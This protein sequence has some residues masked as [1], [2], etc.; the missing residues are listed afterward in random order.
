MTSLGHHLIFAITLFERLKDRTVLN[1]SLLIWT[2]AAIVL[3]SAFVISRLLPVLFRRAIKRFYRHTDNDLKEFDQPLRISFSFLM[4]SIAFH[5]LKTLLH[6]SDSIESSLTA[7]IR[8]AYILSI[9]IFAYTLIPLFVKYGSRRGRSLIGDPKRS[10]TLTH[11]SILLI[12]VLIIAFAAVAVFSVW[13]VNVSGIL[14]GLGIGGLAISLAAQDTLSNLI[15][16]V[17]IMADHPFEIG[18]F[19]RIGTNEGTIEEIGFRSTKMRTLDGFLVVIPNSLVV[20]DSLV[21]ITRMNKRRVRIELMI[22]RDTP[23]DTVKQFV[24]RL[25]LLVRSRERAMADGI[26]VALHGVSGTAQIIL[27]QY[28]IENTDY[29]VF[30]QEQEQL[31]YEINLL[32]EESDIRPVDPLARRLEA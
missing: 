30:A 25:G 1:N 17:T 21:N 32:L 27:V 18:D 26:L 31:L 6:T 29:G 24:D 12:K 4:F 15:G 13:G 20:N 11:Y 22:R 19:V 10:D 7:L 14:T 3:V 16:G 2:I 9:S 23:A 8:T 5:I 28:Y